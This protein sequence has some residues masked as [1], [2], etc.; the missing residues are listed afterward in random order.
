MALGGTQRHPE[1][2]GGIRRH[3]VAPG[4]TMQRT[5]SASFIPIHIVGQTNSLFCTVCFCFYHAMHI[6]K[7]LTQTPNL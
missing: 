7:F 5:S 6:N 3:L 1:V 2:P 4:Q